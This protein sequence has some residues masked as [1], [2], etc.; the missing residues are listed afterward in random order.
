MND[1]ARYLDPDVL[2]HL[3]PLSGNKVA[4][5]D[6]W[7]VVIDGL[8]PIWPASRTQLDGLS[9]GDAWPCAA[10]AEEKAVSVGSAESM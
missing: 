10:L 5:D 8:G 3:R 6:I 1:S 4:L 7:T 9:L 2:D